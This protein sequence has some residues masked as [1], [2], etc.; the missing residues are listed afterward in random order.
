MKKMCKICNIEYEAVGNKL[1]CDNCN[2]KKCVVCGKEFRV[3]FHNKNRKTCS[4]SCGAKNSYPHNTGLKSGAKIYQKRIK[5]KLIEEIHGE[6]KGLEIREKLSIKQLRNKN[7]NYNGGITTY[8]RFVEE[9]CEICNKNKAMDVH[10]KDRNRSN[11]SIYNLISLCRRCHIKIH[12]PKLGNNAIVCLS[13][14]LDSTIALS[15][16]LQKFN[17]VISISFIYGQKHL[18]EI[19]SAK[20]ISEIAGIEHHILH[21]DTLKEIG[22]NSALLNNNTDI[23]ETIN[24]LPSSFVP[25]RNLVFLSFAASLA[26]K[27]NFK[28]IV[29]GVCKED[30]AGYPD[31]R[32]DFI[33][34]VEKTLRGAYETDIYIHTPIIDI[35]K[36][37]T[38]K[39]MNELGNLNWLKYTHTCYNG[40]NPPCNSC[41]SCITRANGFKEAGISD[42][43]LEN[44]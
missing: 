22:G 23:N 6:Q 11:N 38:I 24:N 36:S 43:L 35:T 10:H 3:Y 31:C 25:G 29:L 44:K 30:E 9:N 34:S 27:N 4:K 37:E 1:I 2:I 19:E 7:K 26:Y 33:K 14:G 13:G 16:A 39:M 42:P 40:Q 12:R 28:H 21:I 20:K 8:R 18:I 32:K 5:G 17:K 41:P 15:W